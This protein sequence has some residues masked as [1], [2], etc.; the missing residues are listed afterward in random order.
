MCLGEGEEGI[1]GLLAKNQLPSSVTTVFR[2]WPSP[3]DQPKLTSTLLQWPP[4]PLRPTH[5]APHIPTPNQLPNTPKPRSAPG[6]QDGKSQA[7]RFP[8]LPM[9]KNK[10]NKC[11][12]PQGIRTQLSGSPA[13]PNNGKGTPVSTFPEPLS[14]APHRCPHGFPF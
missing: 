12:P 13:P 14:I 7:S 1:Q 5:S 6:P 8:V 11:N 9:T 4:C 2:R 3:S 10:T